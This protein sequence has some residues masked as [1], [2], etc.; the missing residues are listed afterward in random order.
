[1]WEGGAKGFIAEPVVVLQQSLQGA[2]DGGHDAR[3][4]KWTGDMQ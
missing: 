1:M 2:L 4:P 3:V